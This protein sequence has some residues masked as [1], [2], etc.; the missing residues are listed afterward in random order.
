MANRTATGLEPDWNRIT[1]V[2]EPNRISD[3]IQASEK[4]TAE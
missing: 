2:S 3:G 4:T 1:T